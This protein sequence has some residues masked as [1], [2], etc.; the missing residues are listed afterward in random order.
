MKIL[1]RL[2]FPLERATRLKLA[3]RHPTNIGEPHRNPAKR[4]QWVKDE[5]RNDRR[6]GGRQT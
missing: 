5:Q 4:F 1:R 2:R 6:F 3:S